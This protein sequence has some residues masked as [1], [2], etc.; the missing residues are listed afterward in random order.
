MK[1]MVTFVFT[2]FI[3]SFMAMNLTSA[4][5]S[6]ST[7]IS[8]NSVDVKGGQ[9]VEITFKL[10]GY[11]GIK[12]GI[13]AYQATLVYNDK[14]FEQVFQDSFECLN[15]WEGLLYNPDNKEFVS[16]KKVGSLQNEA[17]AK[18]KLKVKE[19]IK[20]TK[21]TV[22]IK[23]IV[24]S[25]GKKDI[26]VKEKSISLNIIDEQTSIPSDKDV[27]NINDSSKTTT[28]LGT[29]PK[30]SLVLDKVLKVADDIKLLE[31]QD[32]KDISD[33]K[34]TIK[35]EKTDKKVKIK[36]TS[37]SYFWLF[38]LLLAEALIIFIIFRVRKKR[39]EAGLDD[40]KLSK[41]QKKFMVLFIVLTLSFEFIGTTAKAFYDFSQKG[42]L[43]D[44]SVVDYID[45]NSLES[46]LI[47][48]NKLP[49]SKYENADMNSDGKITVTDLTLLVQKLENTLDYE[50]WL[51]EITP[52]TYYPTKS[53]EF[54]LTF[55][56]AVNYGSY[57]EKVIIND[58]EYSVIKKDEDSNKYSLKL[59]APKT[60]G[61]YEYKFTEATLNNGKKIKLDSTFNVDILKDKPSIDNYIV[62]EDVSDNDNLKVNLSFDYNDAD[63][64]M[65]SGIISV[66]DENSKVVK[67]GKVNKGKNKLEVPV[68]DG[69]HYTI[70][71]KVMYNLDS[72]KLKDDK[73]NSGTLTFEKDLMLVTDYGF[74]I[75]NINAYKN[76]KI[77]SDFEKEE[78]IEFG[79]VSSNKS[80]Y[81]PDTVKVNGK[82]YDLTKKNDVYFASLDG[83]SELG[84]KEITIEEVVLAN[85]KKFT[86]KKDN[87]VS[88]NIIKRK[89]SVSG[90]TTTENISDSKLNVKFDLNDKDNAVKNAKVVLYDNAGSEISSKTLTSEEIKTGKIDKSLTTEITSKYKVKVI[91][92]YSQ[93]K[94]DVEETLYEQ[95]VNALPNVKV[96]DIEKDKNYVSKGG[97]VTL[98][99]NI[100]SN[101][102]N[103]ISK[104]RIN[105]TDCIAQKLE[106]GKYKVTYQLGE[107]AGITN[108]V[109][110]KLIYADNSEATINKTVKIEVLKD[111]PVVGDFVIEDDLEN[112]SVNIGFNVND[113]ENSFVSG[114]AVL[115]NT[116]DGTSVSKDI[117]KGINELTFKVESSVKYTFDV[118]VTYD[119]DTNSLEGTD[120]SDN[121]VSNKTLFTT[122]VWQLS[123]YEVKITD[124]KTYNGSAES[125]YF[126]KNKPISVTFGSTNITDFDLNKVIINGKLYDLT[127]DGDL[128]KTTIDSYNTFGKKD[129]VIEGVVFENS[130]QVILDGNDKITVE[131]LKDVPSIDNFDYEDTEEGKMNVSFDVADKDSSIIA[132]NIVI[133]DENDKAIIS[134]EI[135]TGKNT[136]SFNMTDS[137]LYTVTISANYDLDTNA[138]DNNSNVHSDVLL[139]EEISSLANVI[140]LKDVVSNEL[141]DKNH[142]KIEKLNIT[143]GIP[144]DLDN[145]YVKVNMKNL[146]TYYANVKS[147]K[148]NDN[149]L[150]VTIDQTN[151]IMYKKNGDSYSKLNNYSFQIPYIDEDGTHTLV[152]SASELFNQ[153]RQNPSG[154]FVLTEDLDASGIALDNAN[155][156]MIPVTF[157]GTLDGD[158]HKIINIS[159]ALFT[160]INRGTVKNLVIQSSNINNS[161]KGFLANTI[162]NNSM[163]Q[164]VHIKDSNLSNDQGQ[165]GAFTGEVSGSTIKDSS[166]ININVT[167]SNTVGGIA[168]QLSSGSVV[169]NCYVTGA[170]RGTIYHGMGARVGGITG[171]HSGT[172]IDHVYTNVHII[173]ES[174]YGN[175]GIIGGSGDNPVV[176]NSISLSYGNTYRLSGYSKV[177]SMENVYE[178][179]K[180]NGTTNINNN[181]KNIQAITDIYDKDFYKNTLGFD[182]DV[183]NLDLVEHNNLPNLKGDPMP[184]TLDKYEL[185]T[186]KN[187]IPNYAEVRANSAYKADKEIA[188]YNL[189]RLMPFEN[190]KNWVKMAKSVSNDSLLAT[191]KIKFIL[192]LGE[193]DKL[194][195]GITAADTA[196]IKKIRIVYA[197][198]EREDFNVNYKTTIED[199]VAIYNIDGTKLEY[200]FENYVAKV[201]EAK[202]NRAVTLADSLDY[203][204]T[205]AA[206]TSENESRLYVDFYN[207]SV[208]GNIREI[209]YNY[210]ADTSINPSY[211][212]VSSITSTIDS[213]LTEEKLI[214]FLYAYNY[215]EKWYHFDLDGI[216][217]SDLLFFNGTKF[218]K[219]MNINYMVNAVVNTNTNNRATNKTVDFY[220]AF[221]N[222][223]TGKDLPTFLAYLFK[224]V[225]GYDDPSDWF[226]DHFDGILHEQPAN[227]SYK[228][229]VIYRIWPIMQRSHRHVI[230]PILSAPNEDMYIISCPS[231][232]VIGS[233]NRYS[234]YLN[235]DG[236]ER[237]RM[238]NAI[239][240]YGK[241]LGDFYGTSAGF[242]PNSVSI[243]NGGRVNIQYDTRFYFPASSKADGGTQSAGT[244]KDPVMKWVYEA[245]GNAWAAANGSGAYA[246]GSDVWW[247]VDS[248]LGGLTRSVHVFTH[249]TAH[250]QDGRYFYSNNGRRWYTG[251]EAHADG[252]TAQDISTSAYFYNL[253]NNFAIDSDYATNLTMER[254][255]TTDKI[256]DY[257]SQMYETKYV[258][259]YLSAKAFL[260]LTP[261]EQAKVAVQLRPAESGSSRATSYVRLSAEEFRNMNLK[262]IEDLWDNKLAL[263]G[264]GGSPNAQAGSYGYD[265][266]FNMYF[267]IPNNPSGV[268]DTNTFKNTGFEMLGYAGYD[269]GFITYMSGRSQNDGDAIR[270]IT[271]DNDMTWKKYKMSRYENVEKNLSKIKYFDTDEIMD[272]YETALKKDAANG[273]LNISQST[274]KLYYGI[275]KRATNDFTTGGI[276]K[277]N[278]IS[279][280]SAEQL[281]ELANKNVIGNYRVDADLDFSNITPSSGSAY[282]TNKFIGTLDGNGHKFKGMKYTLFT[283]IVY[284]EVKNINIE[285][286]NFEDSVNAYLSVNGKNFTVS[287]INVHGA[288]AVLPNIVSKSGMYFTLG[289][290]EYTTRKTEIKTKEQFLAINN[291]DM[292]RRKEYVLKVDINL[293]D[294][295]RT[296]NPIISGNFSGSIDGEG[297]KISNAKDVLF[298]NV[299]GTIKNLK[300]ENS[301]VTGNNQKGILAN[302]LNNATVTSVSINNSSISNDSNQV[303]GL[304]GNITNSTV[305][306]ISLTD[307][308]VRGNNTVGGL[309][310]QINTTNVSNILFTGSVIGTAYHNLGSRAGG[311]TGWL[312]SG[313]SINYSVVKA[314]VNGSNKN[315]NGGIIGGPDGGNAAISNSISLSTG[316]RSYRIAG[317]NILNNVNNVYEYASSN[318]STNI[319]ANNNTKVLLATDADIQ[320]ASFYANSVKLDSSIWSFDTVSS[321]GVPKLT[322]VTPSNARIRALIKFAKPKPIIDD[323]TNESN[324][325]D[326]KDKELDN[327]NKDEGEETDKDDTLVED[328][329]GVG[330]VTDDE[331]GT[332]DVITDPESGIDMILA[333]V[334]VPD[335]LKNVSVFKVFAGIV[336]LAFGAFV[337]FNVYQKKRL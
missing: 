95:D 184:N 307:V 253:T 311:I 52:K 151:F 286:P 274:T 266:F 65:T 119:R 156:P 324:S 182:T 202:L 283:N 256:N 164:N 321:G 177:G 260:K 174:N 313:A 235:K 40:S 188:Y 50:V 96:T 15:D 272:L 36:K 125:K 123:D 276:Y 23:N 308:T 47:S 185:Y 229:K 323:N 200:Q 135:K 161:T 55:D 295:A 6:V 131:I 195:T 220:N 53:S 190:T 243:L 84:E 31:K 303:G 217:V 254:I 116:E 29:A 214:R 157:K 315:G 310:G 44:D 41:N 69:K 281:V 100:N 46:H 198:D 213:N 21:T 175:G 265:S 318:S 30:S 262:T 5:A 249:E 71:I 102:T 176:K 66:K 26:N 18:I 257:Y 51:S 304:C 270:K 244:T 180:A 319:N 120:E 300:V 27:P 278:Q 317:F 233:M 193:N 263:R 9:E 106:D 221:I 191:S 335:T 234:S 109:T 261:E 316:S 250:N 292:S 17:V 172:K 264:T 98:T 215:Y 251:G 322:N 285:N 298:N 59:S 86:L 226:V 99:Y 78:K 219:D 201:D 89:P 24:V 122:N 92:I 320:K 148:E 327:D 301:T 130:K 305:N 160:S 325:D 3:A 297:H 267:F 205:I 60:A 158:G 152:K 224:A 16:Y 240:N 165:V 289:S 147:I 115:T 107:T 108:L 87:N 104:I 331:S 68:V 216:K 159:S 103:D 38:L 7:V 10:D 239:V 169:D 293:A 22:K 255:N 314:E 4:E 330:E 280:T 186:N 97:V 105:N 247:V 203:A 196:K 58:K 273:N 246:N 112:T 42:E 81:E 231:Q 73:D 271:G 63:D 146:P 162:T 37:N 337:L 94:E 70:N 187:G 117:K 179:S 288:T 33:E 155:N 178:Y 75:S 242:I 128:Y 25:E 67:S 32:S 279:I 183:W 269:K 192:A 290:K 334:N 275:M 150:T 126:A 138:L 227:G 153:I 136:L 72:N 232:F 113:K 259:E 114:K 91:V 144:T 129:I 212:E 8:T 329:T 167:G 218:N 206:I 77:T 61:V 111:I 83:I 154:N 137:D 132:G 149:K 134:K 284:A 1:K 12:K 62:K 291:S 35:K 228:D 245:I 258:L 238:K 48:L 302:S 13:N 43:N 230:L 171:W 85:G 207:E 101:K 282:I 199:L 326:S 93:D 140:E 19:D 287:D 163:I 237:T 64:S 204:S 88:I 166:A 210:L 45:V 139:E 82:V 299:T 211:S 222:G 268:S 20:A 124:L 181:T 145:Y 236:N 141:Y 127:K 296:G 49:E 209:I 197:N 14:I 173:A 312:S 248:A 133:K 336:I 189:S 80:I 208:K 306:K 225:N 54:E 328:E 241:A 2:F 28:V 90:F 309:T 56:G 142:N 277:H 294:V 11:T 194:I 76:D 223:K 110:T 79:F 332:Q 333:E 170:I 57:I 252:V 121:L 118:K 74:T 143:D 39:K 34:G 168:G